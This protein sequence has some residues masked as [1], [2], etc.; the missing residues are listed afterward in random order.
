MRRHSLDARD[1]ARAIT[2]GLGVSMPTAAVMFADS[3]LSPTVRFGSKPE[4]ARPLAHFG[5]APRAAT[6]RLW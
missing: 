4:I 6:M 2:V 5:G 3:A 1:L